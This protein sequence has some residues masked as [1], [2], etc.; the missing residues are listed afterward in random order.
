MDGTHL[1]Y[2]GRLQL[3]SSV[4][5]SITNYWISVYR[6]PSSCIMEI[7]QLCSTFLWSGPELNS[8][9][10]KVNW[11]EVCHPKKEGGLGLQYLKEANKIICLK[12]IWRILYAKDSI[13]VHWI[14]N[15]ILKQKTFWEIKAASTTGS[16]MWE[17]LLKYRDTAKLFYKVQIQNGNSSSFWFDKWSCL[18]CLQDITGSR[19]YIDLGI[20]S[21]ATVAFAKANRRRRNHRF[22]SY[23]QI[24]EEI[25]KVGLNEEEDVPLWRSYNDKYKETFCTKATKNMV[26]ISYPCA[27]WY[28]GVW[29]PN[30][31]P[32]YSF[33]TWLA[34]KNRPSTGDWIKNGIQ[35]KEHIVYFVVIQQNP[36]TTYFSLASFQHT[37]GP[38]S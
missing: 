33:F 7:D 28:K 23:G 34:I 18:G 14:S 11:L 24:E 15:T 26:R 3:L 2:A 31:T 20:P 30:S 17:M 6:L 29:F 5:S 21:H 22:E 10:A 4:I 13:W 8:N 32:K 9:K 25:A 38:H 35:T 12:L 1:S 16:W 27:D 36:E 19:G 37:S